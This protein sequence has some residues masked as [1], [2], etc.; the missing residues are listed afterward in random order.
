MNANITQYILN[1]H[2]DLDG[3]Y[4]FAKPMAFATREEALDYA[5]ADRSRF[6]KSEQGE[7]FREW[8]EDNK[9]AR[10]CF[11]DSLIGFGHAVMDDDQMRRRVYSLAETSLVLEIS[12]K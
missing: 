8:Y 3:N 6:L 11:R 1:C 12:V 5:V 2:M 7:T 10:D 9:E 4:E